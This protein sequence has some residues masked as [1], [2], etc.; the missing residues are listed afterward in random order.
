MRQR[1]G[2]GVSV[3]VLL[4]KSVGF[5][6]KSLFSVPW[7][8]PSSNREDDILKCPRDGEHCSL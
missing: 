5:R 3:C 6:G 8:K 7:F 2:D 4:N 1:A